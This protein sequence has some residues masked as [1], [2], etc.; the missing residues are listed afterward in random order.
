MSK[1]NIFDCSHKIKKYTRD[2][3]INLKEQIEA[4]DDKYHTVILTMFKEDDVFKYTQNGNGTFSDISLCSDITF[5]KIET[6]IDKINDIKNNKIELDL[7]ILPE[8]SCSNV[9]RTYKLSN[10]EMNI[11]KQRNIKKCSEKKFDDSV[12]VNKYGDDTVRSD[13]TSDNKHTTNKKNRI[14]ERISQE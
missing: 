7:D 5:S 9:G 4:L 3:I 10:Y 11:I 14:I 1:K 13:N 2:D 12:S 6:F 8:T